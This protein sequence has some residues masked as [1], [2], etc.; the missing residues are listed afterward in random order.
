[1]IWAGS[2]AHS[3]GGE[4]LRLLTAPGPYKQAVVFGEASGFAKIHL[5]LVMQAGDQI[6]ALLGQAGGRGV[7]AK[8]AVPQRNV[9]GGQRLCQAAEQAQVVAAQAVERHL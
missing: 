5:A 7:F 1:V 2:N 8:G 6:H 4:D 9:P 3:G